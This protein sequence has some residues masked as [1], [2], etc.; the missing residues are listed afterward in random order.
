MSTQLLSKKLRLFALGVALL[1]GKTLSAQ[2]YTGYSDT[3]TN[4]GGP[5]MMTYTFQVPPGNAYLD[6]SLTVNLDGDYGATS[7]Y[8]DI[9]SPTGALI[10]QFQTN[11][12]DCPGFFDAET[13]TIPMD[14][15]NAWC[16]GVSNV[17]F[18]G[19]TS[20]QVD[21]FCN[22]LS[23]LTFEYESC[24][25][26]MPSAF[27]SV[28]LA[29]SSFCSIDGPQP[30]TFSPPG[31]TLS[32][33]NVVGTDVDPSGLNP[34]DY[35]VVYEQF[36]VPS[37]CFTKDSIIY[38]IK[39]AP[40]DI[41]MDACPGIGEVVVP[42]TN[43]NA[44]FYFAMDSTMSPL[45]DSGNTYTAPALWSTGTFAYT[46]GYGSADFVVDTFNT[47]NSYVIDHNGI[48]G[49]DRAGIIVTNN[50]VYVIGD[51]NVGRYDH[52]LLLPGTPYPINDGLFSDLSSGELWTIHDGTS[53]PVWPGAYQVS[54][55]RQLNDDLTENGNIVTLSQT[56][57]MSTTGDAGIFSGY[58]ILILYASADNKWYSIEIA[59]GQVTDLGV[60]GGA[61]DMWNGEN[62]AIWGNAEYDGTD[63]YALYRAQSGD[64][65]VRRNLTTFTNVDHSLFTNVSDMCSFSASP[66]NN[67]WYF[68]Y[69]GGGEFGGSSETLGYCDATMTAG[70][71]SI[72]STSCPSDITIVVSDI[73]LGAD[74]T[75]CE[76]DAVVLDA[77]LG[78]TSYT[79]NGDNNNLNSYT[80][81]TTE[82]IE[83]EAID[84]N[85][86]SVYDT[87]MVTVNPMAVADF[88]FAQSG[89]YAFD[90]TDLS[91]GTPTTWDWDFGDGNTDNVQNPSHT[92][93]GEGNY[94]VTLTVT[95]GCNSD[96]YTMNVG[97]TVG[98]EDLAF[99]EF[100]VY[101]NPNNG[102]FN[103]VSNAVGSTLTIF[104]IDGSVVL[105]NQ[106][107]VNTNQAI[108][109][110]DVT[111]GVYFASMTNG[112]TQKTIRFVI[113]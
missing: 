93:A 80:A 58:G 72:T 89:P 17:Q 3:I 23:F 40:A 112:E 103:I 26:G 110:S 45:L 57:N 100:T 10:G 44:F 98:V 27:A 56:I 82:T 90:F 108:E 42:S 95:N 94:T 36:D 101:P 32:G 49:D 105:A 19:I 41:V 5:F 91:A 50:Y 25:G 4:G 8:I 69:E 97:S 29:N 28:S 63:Y 14:S 68:H 67:R 21:A 20:V 81:T 83:L 85:G 43:T 84:V 12:G 111:P 38:T 30:L 2:L 106:P 53:N 99:G 59:S 37:G 87:I 6:G 60:D 70:N 78:Y 61:L 104:A 66:F 1:F 24:P 48:T 9:Y 15:I 62:W 22:N 75:F 39:G 113:Q 92:Y 76:P 11:S 13:V 55:L 34:G 86:C 71:L 65:I 16:D 18:T 79:W 73:D 74:T 31:G 88:S 107:I 64:K 7:E 35:Y 52:D 47:S 96:T 51:N 77:G 46:Q 109:L 33:I 102:Q 54:E